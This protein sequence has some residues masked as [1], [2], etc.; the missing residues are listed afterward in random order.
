MSDQAPI[1]G[2]ASVKIRDIIYPDGD[3][4]SRKQVEDHL[5]G[6]GIPVHSKIRYDITPIDANGAK[7]PHGDPRLASGYAD[8]FSSNEEACTLNQ[9]GNEDNNPGN[10]DHGCTPLGKLHAEGDFV[11]RHHWTDKATGKQVGDEITMPELH[12]R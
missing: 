6:E 8:S 7:V 9:T 10:N 1:I 3:Q 2:L 5:N 4:S 11:T 12:C